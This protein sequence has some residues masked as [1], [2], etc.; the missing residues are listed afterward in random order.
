VLYPLKTSNMFMT[1]GFLHAYE[2]QLTLSL[3][4]HPGLLHYRRK[5]AAICEYPPEDLP[6]GILPDQ[7]FTTRVINCEAGDILV[8][9]TDGITEVFDQRAE[10]MGVEPI[11]SALQRWGHLPLSDIF[12]KI[13]E[14]A[15]GFGKQQDDQTTLLVRRI[16][17]RKLA[18]IA[19][20]GRINTSLTSPFPDTILCREPTAPFDG[21]SAEGAKYDC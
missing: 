17:S 1:A 19:L 12:Q 3:A 9:L 6:L 15:L 16:A 10:E 5:S 2:D 21:C 7:S 20:S 13:R 14:L 8:L 4:G 18:G 11:K